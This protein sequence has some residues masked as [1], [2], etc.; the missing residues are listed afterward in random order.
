MK[1]E[2]KRSTFVMSIILILLLF[3]SV[4]LVGG[5]CGFAV[6]QIVTKALTKPTHINSIAIQNQIRTMSELATSKVSYQGMISYEEGKYAFIDKKK[7]NM[8]Y[9][10]EVKAGVDL[11]KANVKVDEKN[12]TITVDLPDP[13]I[14]SVYIDPSQTQFYDEHYSLFNLPD[15]STGT[16]AMK[17]AEEDSLD[18]V[19]QEALIASAKKQAEE[20]VSGLVKI[21]VPEDYTIEIK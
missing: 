21:G 4:F 6:D 1:I 18:H 12:K 5:F 8:I 14:L 16:Q 15:S 9:T 3:C 13:E 17:M 20:V 11:S 2:M 10:S 19:D 7:Y